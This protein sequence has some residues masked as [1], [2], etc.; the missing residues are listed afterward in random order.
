MQITVKTISEFNK[1]NQFDF[2]FKLRCGGIKSDM[3]PK[4]T[5]VANAIINCIEHEVPMKFTA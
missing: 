1:V 5:F 3:F 2:G 4:P